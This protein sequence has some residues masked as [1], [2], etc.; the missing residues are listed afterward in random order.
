MK[1]ASMK[2]KVSIS[3]TTLAFML[4]IDKREIEAKEKKIISFNEIC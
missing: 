2:M 1:R 3:V 4:Q